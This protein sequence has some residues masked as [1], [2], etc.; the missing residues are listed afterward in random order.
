M[1]ALV[2]SPDG[3]AVESNPAICPHR[4]ALESSV[5]ASTKASRPPF[6]RVRPRLP[7]A[8]A[9][10]TSFPRCVCRRPKSA[11]QKTTGRSSVEVS[12]GHS[13]H[14]TDGMPFAGVLAGV[15]HDVI[16]REK[17]RPLSTSIASSALIGPLVSL[18]PSRPLGRWIA[19]SEDRRSIFRRRR[20]SPM[21]REDSATDAGD[22]PRCLLQV[23]SEARACC[24]G[25]RRSPTAGTPSPRAARGSS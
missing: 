22:H 15:I 9:S 13:L 8:D 4:A 17:T 23:V 16:R 1:T 12:P 7:K 24:R 20:S 6:T 14:R 25:A 10:S 19:S 2:T 3:S 21:K 11:V 5:I 18:H